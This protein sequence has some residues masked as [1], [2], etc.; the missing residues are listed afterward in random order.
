MISEK[1]TLNSNLCKLLNGF[2]NFSRNCPEILRN[3]PEIMIQV[4]NFFPF[5]Q[6]QSDRI[7]A[8]TFMYLVKNNNVFITEILYI[9]SRIQFLV[10]LKSNR[11]SPTKWFPC[12]IFL[13]NIS[14][15][16]SVSRT[17][18]CSVQYGRSFEPWMPYTPD[19]FRHC[20]A[21]RCSNVMITKLQLGAIVALMTWKKA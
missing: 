20:D 1:K 10:P 11:G 4:K 3:F 9:N 2:L 8:K 14:L 7:F 13:V 6:N 16:V 17:E 19:A 18:R 15:Y 5:K 21:E 12:I